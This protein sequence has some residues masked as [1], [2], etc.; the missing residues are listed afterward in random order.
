MLEV[1]RTGDCGHKG[2]ITQHRHP[3]EDRREDIDVS[4]DFPVQLATG[5]TSGN[6]ASDV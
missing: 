2:H 6:R 5:I 4:G 3:R 1:E